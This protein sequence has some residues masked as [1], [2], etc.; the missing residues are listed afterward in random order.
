ME[1]KEGAKGTVFVP[2]NPI[3]LTHL[4]WTRTRTDTDVDQSTASPEDLEE[5]HRAP[6]SALFAELSRG[7]WEPYAPLGMCSHHGDAEE[8]RA[9]QKSGSGVTRPERGCLR[10]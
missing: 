7:E 5:G 4:H 10:P 1:L 9:T 8:G 2:L 3:P 6:E